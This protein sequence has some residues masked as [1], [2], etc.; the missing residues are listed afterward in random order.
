VQEGEVRAALAVLK[1][2]GALPGSAPR[3]GAE[4][5]A[6]LAE[7]DRLARRERATHRDLGRLLA[8]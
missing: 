4:D 6:E 8:P 7:E 1:G 2:L 5:P 3:I